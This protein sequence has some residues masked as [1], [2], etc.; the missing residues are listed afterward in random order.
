M[1]GDDA[2]LVFVRYAPIAFV[3]AGVLVVVWH[4]R[5]RLPH[6]L[7]PDVLAALSDSEALT[8]TSIRERPPLAHQ[9]IDLRMLEHVLDE[10]CTSGRVVRWYERVDSERRVVYRRIKSDGGGVR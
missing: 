8:P 1:G 6:E 10:L 2:F 9:D 3:V 5:Q 7:E 4:S